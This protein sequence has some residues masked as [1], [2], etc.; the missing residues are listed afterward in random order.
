MNRE[1]FNKAISK[2]LYIEDYHMYD[3]IMASILCN[4]MRLGDPVWLTLIGPSS[5]GKSQI[6]RPFSLANSGLIY[7]IDDMTANSLISGT[8]GLENSLLGQIGDFGILSIDDL[9]VLFSKNQEERK[10]ILSQFRMLYDGRL[11]K[12]AGNRKENMRWEGFL[13]MI[14]GSTPAIYR[15]FNEVADMGERFISYR[16]K[17]YDKEKALAFITNNPTTSKELDKAI[18]DLI[19]VRIESLIADPRQ[20]LL[21]LEPRVIDR[22]MQFSSHCTL[23]RTPVHIDDR[24]GLVDELPEPEMPL[25]VFKQLLPLAKALQVVLGEKLNDETLKPL[26]WV[27]YS[28][29]DDKRRQYL[30]AAV[31][32]KKTG[33]PITSR[34]LSCLIGLSSE[35]IG[36]GMSQLQALDILKLKDEDSGAREWVVNNP[37][38]VSVVEL[39]DPPMIDN[40]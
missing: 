10:A 7:Q 19:K 2:L 23:L 1:D 20:D 13:G 16:M 27:L 29:A 4:T 11:S 31:S 39:L 8:V 3:I 24:S 22:I 28:L 40:F 5:G 34:E 30:K 15:I 33:K 26:L 18:A 9:T 38:L 6:I 32:L 25:R 37:G 21:E 17:D 35:V 36:K 14:A 12:R